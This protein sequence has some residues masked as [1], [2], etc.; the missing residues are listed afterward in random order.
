[1]CA[2]LAAGVVLA[3]C[4]GSGMRSGVPD[5]YVPNYVTPTPAPVGAIPT[6]VITHVIIIVQENRTTDNMFNGFPGADTV[7][8]GPAKRHGTITLQ[9]ILLEAPGD[10]DHSPLGF[11]IDY[12]NGQNDGWLEEGWSSL[13]PADAPYGYVPPSE[14][15]PDW[16]IAQDYVFADR[17]FQTNQGPSWPAHLFLI[18]GTSAP[19]SGSTLLASENP[20]IPGSPDEVGG[21]DSPPGSIVE[22]MNQNGVNSTT[23]FPCFDHQTLM[24][25]LDAHGLTWRYYEPQIGGY[26]DGPDAI[27]HLRNSPTDWANVVVPETTILSDIQNGDLANVSWVIPNGANSDHAGAL[28]NSG[29]SW[30]ASIINTVGASPYWSSTAVFVTWDDWGGWYDHVV[31]LL[32]GPNEL[33]YRVPL[34]VASPWAKHGYVSHVQHEFGSILHFVEQDFGLGTLGYTDARADDLSDCFDFSQTPSAFR[35]IPAPLPARYFITSHI[36]FSPPDDE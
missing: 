19:S 31:P 21:C 24:D 3:G 13:L 30:V 25:L 2:V 29:P 36:P 17:M 32:Y 9:P 28:S 14:V 23:Q 4:G 34:I 12:D 33:S 27:S 5:A 20:V 11:G 7:T 16:T 22:L 15:Q 6:G 10:L 8:S 26:W 18:S 35:A 1:M